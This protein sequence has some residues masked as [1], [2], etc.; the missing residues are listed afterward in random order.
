M[1]KKYN[2]LRSGVLSK[3]GGEGMVYFV[4]G[5]SLCMCLMLMSYTMGMETFVHEHRSKTNAK[6]C[7]ESNDIA[8]LLKD[9][10]TK[11]EKST[12]D[13]ITLCEFL[14]KGSDA[15]VLAKIIILV[16]LGSAESVGRL[17]L[18]A[19]QQWK[20]L[21]LYNDSVLSS[22]SFFHA[23]SKAIALRKHALEYRVTANDKHIISEEL[24]RLLAGTIPVNNK[25][26]KA[27]LDFVRMRADAMVYLKK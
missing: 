17:Q 14:S 9:Q 13:I 5:C 11:I 26:E 1:L 27:I 15:L 25:V 20:D 3:I 18:K 8:K 6:V 2:M 16:S 24:S 19:L 7:V 10:I 12:V 23:S 22:L 4:R 21:G